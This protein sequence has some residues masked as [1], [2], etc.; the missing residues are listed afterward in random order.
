MPQSLLNKLALVLLLGGLAA[1]ASAMSL[2]RAVAKVRQETGGRVLSA[3]TQEGVHQIRVLTESG[4]VRLIRVPA[5]PGR[6][7]KRQGH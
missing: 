3:Q 7:H 2:D 1:S 6:P 5:G 4:Q